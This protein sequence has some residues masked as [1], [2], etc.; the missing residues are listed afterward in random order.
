LIRYVANKFRWACSNGLEVEDLVQ[1]A[2]VQVCKE[3]H[4]FDRAKGSFANFVSIVSRREIWDYAN[5]WAGVTRKCRRE[6]VSEA[7]REHRDR[8]FTKRVV[9]K[10]RDIF[11][12]MHSGTYAQSNLPAYGAHSDIDRNRRLRWLVKAVEKLPP[13][14]QEAIGADSEYKTMLA[15]KNGVTPQAIDLRAKKAVEILRKS[16]KRAKLL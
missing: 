10:D 3:L 9:A 4:R 2:L 11:D 12:L 16:A 1:I 8:V 7:T 13:Q 14:L 5:V 15:N 6:D